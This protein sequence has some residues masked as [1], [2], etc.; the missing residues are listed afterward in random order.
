MIIILL[1][2]LILVLLLLLILALLLLLPLPQGV[3]PISSDMF[4]VYL[5]LLSSPGVWLYTTL[6]LVV[7]LLPDVVIRSPLLKSLLSLLLLQGAEKT[8]GHHSSGASPPQERSKKENQERILWTEGF[9]GLEG[10]G[11][12][13]GGGQVAASTTPAAFYAALT[14]GE[15]WELWLVQRMWKAGWSTILWTPSHSSNSNR[16]PVRVLHDAKVTWSTKLILW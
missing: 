1:L 14:T 12:G 6:T 8:L 7:A 3:A 13:D 9:P 16:A 11:A 2:L 15:Y 5:H 10:E 4:H